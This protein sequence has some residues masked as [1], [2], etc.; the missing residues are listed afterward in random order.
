MVKEDAC[1]ATSNASSSV[2]AQG[3]Q[4]NASSILVGDHRDVLM[5]LRADIQTAG[6]KSSCKQPVTSKLPYW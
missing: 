4:T 5:G 1:P 2:E 3:T 6:P